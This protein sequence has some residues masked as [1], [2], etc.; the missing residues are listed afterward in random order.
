MD[1]QRGIK[2]LAAL[3]F[4]IHVNAHVLAAKT[5]Q[6]LVVLVHAVKWRHVEAFVEG[7]TLGMPGA[8]GAWPRLGAFHAVNM[9]LLPGRIGY[10]GDDHARNGAGFRP[11][12]P[13][14]AQVKADR[15]ENVAQIAWVGDQFYWPV[16]SPTGGAFNAVEYRLAQAG[17]FRVQVI[18]AV[19][20]QPVKAFEG[21]K[22]AGSGY[23]GPV[24]KVEGEHSDV[25]AEL[26]LNR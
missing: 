9:A 24:V 16:R 3:L 8:I 2:M 13:F 25:V 1:Y 5:E 23:R 18:P 20:P 4:H 7:K 22:R 17:H 12:A 11:A 15:I 19:E 21:K 26:M 6:P 14:I 10:L